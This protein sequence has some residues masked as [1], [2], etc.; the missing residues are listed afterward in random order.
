MRSFSPWS[1]SCP[2]GLPR[3]ISRHMK[4]RKR[5][6]IWR[7]G[8]RGPRRLTDV[9]SGKT[10]SFARRSGS[11]GRCSS[12]SAIL[13]RKSGSWW[14]PTAGKWKRGNRSP[15]MGE[16]NG[17]LSPVCPGRCFYRIKKSLQGGGRMNRIQKVIAREIL[18]SRGNPTVEVDVVLEN[19]VLGRAAI[20][21]GASTG[22]FEAVE[23]RDGDK[24]RYLGKGVLRAVK[25][26]EK[27]IAP[28]VVGMA[29]TD[30][31]ALDR[32][33]IDLDGTPNKE[34]LGANAILAASIAACQSA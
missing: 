6:E 34:K 28:A 29:S 12:N 32:R 1:T 30:Q 10:D 7:C 26:V 13:P 31:L 16:N 23:M 3:S 27:T 5:S 2:P 4:C 20:P 17:L 9:A 18:D 25:N 24:S 33:M 8:F 11:S 19:G 22:E 14:P 21:S 15:V